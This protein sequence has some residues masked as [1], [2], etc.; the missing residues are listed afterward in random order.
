[1]KTFLAVAT[2][3]VA[4]Q[5]GSVLALTNENKDDIKACQAVMEYRVK[6]LE[7]QENTRSYENL[8]AI[9]DFAAKSASFHRCQLKNMENGVSY[10][11]ARIM[12]RHYNN[13]AS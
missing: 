5:S 9:C 12:C 3:L 2:I 10:R 7:A 1:M 6:L 8:T 11:E 13:E 4:F